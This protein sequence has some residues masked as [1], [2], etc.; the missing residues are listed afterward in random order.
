MRTRTH[1][2]SPSTACARVHTHTHTNFGQADTCLDFYVD[3]APDRTC[4]SE[5]CCRRKGRQ[6]HRSSARHRGAGSQAWWPPPCQC[7]HLWSAL[8]ALLQAPSKNFLK[9]SLPPH[10]ST[11]VSEHLSAPSA[12]LTTVKD[13]NRYGDKTRRRRGIKNAASSPTTVKEESPRNL[14]QRR[15]KSQTRRK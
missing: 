8:V 4:V 1:G 5:G 2:T 14:N 9:N 7:I 3:P 12:C 10:S 6:L 13:L 11:E 15:A